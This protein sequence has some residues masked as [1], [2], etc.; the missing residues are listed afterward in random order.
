VRKVCVI[1]VTVILGMTLA[2]CTSSTA[3]IAVRATHVAGVS[4]CTSGS[5]GALGYI[6]STTL[7]GA[8]RAPSVD[9]DVL[10]RAGRSGDQLASRSRKVVLL[11]LGGVAARTG[12]RYSSAASKLGEAVAADSIGLVLDQSADPS[13]DSC[14]Y[15]L[16]DKPAAQ[17]LVNDAVVALE[18]GDFLQKSPP[19]DSGVIEMVSD[20]PLDASEAIV[21]IEV[22]NDSGAVG[23][24]GEPGY[25]TATSPASAYAAVVNKTSGTVSA[26]GLAP[27]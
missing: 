4:G 6:V 9:G 5:R 18:A 16:A 13:L 10:R 3:P 12:G 8:K 22:P 17:V 7:S 15:T 20:D 21:T 2:A 24:T 14:S 27:W 26:V 19:N 23:V 11:P 25:Y 1:V